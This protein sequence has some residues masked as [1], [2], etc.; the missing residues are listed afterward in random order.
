MKIIE[1]G[2]LTL[3]TDLKYLLACP[4]CGC[5]FIFETNEIEKIEKCID[6]NGWIHCPDC[7]CEIEFKRPEAL[8][9]WVE[10]CNKDE[11]NGIVDS[12]SLDSSENYTDGENDDIYAYTDFY[13][14]DDI[15]EKED[16]TKGDGNDKKSDV[17][18]D[19]EVKTTKPN[20]EKQKVKEEGEKKINKDKEYDCL[21]D[22]VIGLLLKGL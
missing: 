3:R 7:K 18:N 2:E 6:G 21:L 15:E 14:N 4:H 19:K 9:A 8:R 1:H 22:S 20:N 5:K 10:S 12:T 13:E 11:D 16:T 17:D